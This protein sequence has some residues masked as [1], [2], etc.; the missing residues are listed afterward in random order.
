VHGFSHKP[1]V[2][3][4]FDQMAT[5]PH[6]HLGLS[7]NRVPLNPMLYHL[8]QNNAFFVLDAPAF[9]EKKTLPRISDTNAATLVAR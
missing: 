5:Q 9:S 6:Q 2:T 8:P 3:K 4:S 1:P 7:E